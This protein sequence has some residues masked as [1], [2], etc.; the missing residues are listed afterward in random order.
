MIPHA[1]NKENAMRNRAL[2]SALALCLSLGACEA[3]KDE[4]PKPKTAQAVVPLPPEAPKPA[5]A[6]AG[7]DAGPVR[8]AQAAQT[9]PATAGKR[10]GC[11]G[12]RCVVKITV[13][14]NVTPCKVTYSTDDLSIY[15]ANNIRWVAQDG[16]LFDK[17]GIDLPAGGGQFSNAAGEGT[18]TYSWDDK[19]SDKLKY[20]YKVNLK[21]GAKT[22]K[23]DPSVVNGADYD[24]PNYPPG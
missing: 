9:D 22:C 14:D 21:K 5:A 7:Q 24:D 2:L 8:L 15:G 17:D 10:P 19:N 12:A 13:D 18:A 1:H 11:A 16:W 20:K 6:S 4:P 3:K 23:G